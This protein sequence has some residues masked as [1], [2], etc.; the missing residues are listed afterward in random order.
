MACH[1]REGIL[2]GALPSCMFSLLRIINFTRESHR[3]GPTE[4]CGFDGVSRRRAGDGAPRCATLGDSIA[5]FV[6]PTFIRLWHVAVAYQDNVLPQTLSANPAAI[7]V[8]HSVCGYTLYRIQRTAGG[9]YSEC[10]GTKTGYVRNEALAFAQL[11]AGAREQHGGV[12]G[13]NSQLKPRAG[14]A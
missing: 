6:R 5:L 10:N 8:I 1:L 2:A 11:V 3:A 9:H 7:G 13:N 4:K 12:V 14:S